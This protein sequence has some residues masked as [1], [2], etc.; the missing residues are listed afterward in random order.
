MRAIWV[1]LKIA[2]ELEPSPQ[3][4]VDYRPSRGRQLGQ[5]SLDIA[6]ALVV[7]PQGGDRDVD[8]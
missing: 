6:A 4:I 8:R 2:W 1:P 3:Q 5:S 7:S